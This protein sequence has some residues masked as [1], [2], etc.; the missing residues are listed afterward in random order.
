MAFK[1]EEKVE[2]E[3]NP[4]MR[5]VRRFLPVSKGY[6]EEKFFV[7]EDGI[8]K[9]TP[10]FLVLI[11]IESTDIVFALDSVPAV[12]SV[13]TDSFIVF[14]SNIFAIMGL[15]SLYFALAGVLQKLCFLH[16]GL[17]AV[18]VFL[19]AKMLTGE[20]VEIPILISLGVIGIILLVAI[21]ASLVWSRKH[22]STAPESECQIPK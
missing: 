1:K 6:H 22:P 14:S 2:P 10:L 9:A 13:T 15:R 16:Y 12:L 11:L 19:G 17:A 5:L 20:F 21:V 18:L 8:R 4:L 7:I 3:H